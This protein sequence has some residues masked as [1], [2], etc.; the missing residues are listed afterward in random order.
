MVKTQSPMQQPRVGGAADFISSLGSK[1]SLEELLQPD[2]SQST[3]KN[4]NITLKSIS[5]GSKDGT[6]K[7]KEGNFVSPPHRNDLPKSGVSWSSRDRGGRNGDSEIPMRSSEHAP[8][9]LSFGNLGNGGCDGGSCGG[10][11]TNSRHRASAGGGCRNS[12]GESS[13]FPRLKSQKTPPKA[14]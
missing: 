4:T 5:T 9:P 7:T 13:S 10:S 6:T 12:V 2:F 11:P 8:M 3:R 1:Y 14:A